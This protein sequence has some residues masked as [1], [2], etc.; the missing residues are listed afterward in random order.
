MKRNNL[1]HIIRASCNCAGLDSIFI[2]GS[3]AILGQHPEL[4]SVDMTTNVNVDFTLAERP[5]RILLVSDEADILVPEDYRKAEIIEG[6]IGEDSLFHQQHGFYAQAVD[7][8]TCKLPEGW[9]NRVIP[10]CNANTSNKTGF[11]LD[12][13]DLIISK[14]I[15]G[16][17][18]DYLY[19]QAACKLCLVEREL[20]IERLDNTLDIPD[21]E[22]TRI[23]SVIIREFGHEP[24]KQIR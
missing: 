18:K 3:Q 6:C 21:T 14:L 17:P 20:L 5:Q 16:R 1:E 7:E 15:A 22:R 8:S 12:T 23:K 13:H 9:K 19:F 4:D 11:C 24:A 10:V 2:M